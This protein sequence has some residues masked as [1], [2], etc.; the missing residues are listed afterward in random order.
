MKNL[1][2]ALETLNTRKVHIKKADGEPMYFIGKDGKEDQSKPTMFTIYST[3]SK[4]YKEKMS[5]YYSVKRKE[6]AKK[7]K[8]QDDD[9]MEVIAEITEQTLFSLIAGWENLPDGAGGEVEFNEHNAKAFAEIPTLGYVHRQIN[10]GAT[11]ENF[12][13]TKG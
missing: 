7:K 8:N 13:Q 3:D 5:K 2:A 1:F 10:E 11:P 4:E 6:A 9:Y 12:M